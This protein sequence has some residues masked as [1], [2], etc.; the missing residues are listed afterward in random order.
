MV[1]PRQHRKLYRWG[2]RQVVSNGQTAYYN[3]NFCRD[4]PHR[5]AR[6]KSITAEK[7]HGH[8]CRLAD[9]R[10]LRESKPTSG[11]TSQQLIPDES[12]LFQHSN[13]SHDRRPLKQIGA[14]KLACQ[15]SGRGPTGSSNP[16]SFPQRNSTPL[17]NVTPPN[18]DA[19]NDSALIQSER[20][21]NAS[22]DRWFQVLVSEYDK[23]Q[24][25]S[26]K[27]PSSLTTLDAT[28]EPRAT[29]PGQQQEFDQRK[30][31]RSGHTSPFAG[32]T[33]S[34]LSDESSI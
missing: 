19:F 27:E 18:Q 26:L 10:K 14:Q 25:G 1:T 16:A 5:I 4:D 2:F 30:G 34:E 3:S 20:S 9:E 8:Y 11:A 12:D 32:W 17:A 23:N 28:A 21:T 22:V 33:S 31:L 24:L 13:Y 7:M 29:S 15:R 6:M